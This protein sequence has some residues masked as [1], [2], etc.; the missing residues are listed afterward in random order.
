M[1]FTDAVSRRAQTGPSSPPTP[2]AAPLRVREDARRVGE[3][4]SGAAGMMRLVD[5]CPR[6]ARIQ[7]ISPRLWQRAEMAKQVP[8]QHI[9]EAL[10]ASVFSRP[11]DCFLTSAVGCFLGSSRPSSRLPFTSS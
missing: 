10:C 1:P 6:L 3:V 11:A 8:Q 9:P 7:D 2:G 4:C 5:G